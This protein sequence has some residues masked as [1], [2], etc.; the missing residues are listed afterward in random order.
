MNNSVERSVKLLR[1]L[2]DNCC[3]LAT[4]NIFFQRNTCLLFSISISCAYTTYKSSYCHW[5]WGGG[6]VRVV[7][8]ERGKLLQMCKARPSPC[9]TDEL[10]LKPA[11]CHHFMGNESLTH[12]QELFLLSERFCG[13]CV[14]ASCLKYG[15]G[16][17]LASITASPARLSQSHSWYNC[18]GCR[19]WH[20]FPAG[21]L[22]VLVFSG[23]GR[24]ELCML[25]NAGLPS[26]RWAC[27]VAAAASGMLLL[28]GLA[29]E[30]GTPGRI[31]PPALAWAQPFSDVVLQSLLVSS[32]GL[33]ILV[34]KTRLSS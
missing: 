9:V 23:G 28:G 26:S 5:H 27:G 32:E 16:S 1:K 6:G 29:W 31:L 18:R 24:G 30:L 25:W 21:P 19:V 33:T 34:Q 3:V 22:P 11:V 8:V 7:R 14:H 20:P 17:P 12:G 10:S 4:M 15:Y 13:Q 2:G